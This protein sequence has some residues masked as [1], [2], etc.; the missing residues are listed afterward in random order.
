MLLGSN[1]D[2]VGGVLHSLD[3]VIVLVL[4]V[5]A[6]WFVWRHWSRGIPEPEKE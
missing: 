4:A 5:G 6:V 2:R 1:W 3:V